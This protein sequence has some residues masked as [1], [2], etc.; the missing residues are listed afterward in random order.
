MIAYGIS[1]RL[2]VERD[3]C[4]TRSHLYNKDFDVEEITVKD[5]E[6]EI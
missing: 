2:C 3:R 5:S 4:F 1:R 6:K